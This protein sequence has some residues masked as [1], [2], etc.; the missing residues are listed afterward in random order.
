MTRIV[1]DTRVL[2]GIVRN[3]NGNRKKIARKFAFMVEARAKLSSPVDTGALRNSI[4]TA[5]QDD[6]NYAVASASARQANPDVLTEPHPGPSG[7]VL[8]VVG[9]CVDYAEYQEF[10]T[11]KMA[12]QP[13]LIPA[14]EEVSRAFENP[15]NWEELVK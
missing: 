13:Y 10:G 3:L 1:V 5:T 9:P 12:A 15:D 2:D 6:D 14:V 4:Y 11:N 8:A 7:G